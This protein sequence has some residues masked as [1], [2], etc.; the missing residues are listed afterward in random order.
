M[1]L[2]FT[3][4]TAADWPE[5]KRIYEEGIATGHGTFE[6][7]AAASWEDFIRTK[8]A[9]CCFVA[10]D[11]KGEMAGW[12]VM[13]PVSSRAVYAGVAEVGLYV[14]E[15]WRGRGAGSAIM[16]EVIRRSEAHGIW[17]LQGGTFPENAASIALQ[18]KH[19]FRLVG[20]RE[21]I[22]K[23]KSGPLA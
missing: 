22:G 12:A 17:T 7:A 6:Y 4:M 15:S 3:V 20:R 18:H 2:S 10:R 11:S 13:S 16:V 21:R 19:G 1:E 14:A 9:A 5:V 8:I 23:M